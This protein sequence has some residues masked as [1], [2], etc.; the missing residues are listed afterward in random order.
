MRVLRLEVTLPLDGR[1][2]IFMG[3]DA[4]I[5]SAIQ[6]AV[7]RRGAD[8]PELQEIEGEISP[9]R[10]PTP[11]RDVPAWCNLAMEN[12]PEAMRYYCGFASTDQL[13]AWFDS[14]ALRTAMNDVGITLYEYEV[15]D[16]YVMH[17]EYQ[18]MFRK[19][20]A[21]E[22]GHGPVP[23]LAGMQVEPAALAA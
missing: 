19:D 7:Q 16:E 3:M 20:L 21:T 11:R 15:A 22:M 5:D 14:E 13:L 12:M 2:G 8:W 6:L 17:G 23:T 10:H 18:V 1:A 9:Y 4:P